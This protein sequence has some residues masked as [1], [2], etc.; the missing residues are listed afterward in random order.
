MLTVFFPVV[1]GHKAVSV[2]TGENTGAFTLKSRSSNF[3]LLRAALAKD[4]DPMAI[5]VAALILSFLLSYLLTPLIRRAAVHWGFVDRPDAH[6]KIQTS[7]VSLGGGIGLFIATFV[8]VHLAAVLWGWDLWLMTDKP[9]SVIGLGAA[10]VLL[11]TVGLVDDAVGIRG[12]YKLF[13]QV[14]AASLVM[15]GDLN[16]PA[17]Q[18]FGTTIELGFFGGLVAI[19]WLLAAINSLNLIDGVDGLAGS[20]GVVFSLTLGVIAFWTKDYLDA[21]IAFSLAGSL[22]GFLRYNFPPAT[23]YLGDAGSMLI[24]LVLGGIALRCTSK[25]AATTAFAALLAIW[26][27]PMFDAA[28]AII[29]RKLT[30]RSIYATDRGHIHHVLLTRGMSAAQAVALITG[31]CIVTSFGAVVSLVYEVE[32]F[33][34]AVVVAVIGLLVATR[35]FGHVEFLLVNTRLYG[36][37]RMLSPFAER[38]NPGGNN[39]SLNIQGTGRWENLW[40]AILESVDR[41]QISKMRLNLSLPRQHEEF[42]ATW[43]RGGN[44]RQQSVWSVEIPLFV[45]DVCVGRLSASGCQR[46]NSVASDMSAFLD[47]VESVESQLAVLARQARPSLDSATSGERSDIATADFEDNAPIVRQ[48]LPEPTRG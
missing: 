45:D 1:V 10:A 17:L 48:G 15:G 4:L 14:V 32:W 41:F 30:G 7:A 3:V 34:I 47:F 19:I 43:S 23:I 38:S 29:R 35:I 12:S 22:L 44:H 31:L 21:L 37:G 36:V 40:G 42:Y 9:I 11:V 24:G 18:I 33:G 27:I 6:R 13:W 5:A 8:V 26:S 20:V 46:Q 39:S 28:A 2:G 16:V 25:Q